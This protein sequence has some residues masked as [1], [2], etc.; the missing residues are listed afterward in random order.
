MVLKQ[1]KE[2]ITKSARKHQYLSWQ[3]SGYFY[4]PFISKFATIDKHEY[5]ASYYGV[6]NL[7]S[8][9]KIYYI[10]VLS[11]YNGN[12][13]LKCGDAWLEGTLTDNTVDKL[14]RMTLS[15]N[16]ENNNTNKL[17]PQLLKKSYNTV[18]KS[19]DCNFDQNHYEYA[20]EVCAHV[21]NFLNDLPEDIFDNLY[22][23]YNQG[24]N[25]INITILNVNNDLQMKFDRYAFKKHILLEGDKGSGKTYAATMWGKEKNITQLFVGGHE[26]FESIDFLGHYIQQKSGEL[27]WKDGS[28][29]EA[30]RKAKVGEKT[31]LILDE[32]LRIPKRELNLLISALSPIDGKYVLRTGRAISSK[33][34]IAIEEVIY[35]PTENLWVIGTTNIGANYAVESMDEALIDRFK[36]IRKDTTKE[37]MRAIL[38]Q[39]AK[40]RKISLIHVDKLV[41]FYSKMNR[42]YLTKIINKIVNIRHLNEALELATNHSE[43][44][45]ILED[46]ILLWVERDYDGYP[47]KEQISAVETVMRT[48]YDYE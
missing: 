25:G 29:S 1:L 22:M 34:D 40:K 21:S 13:M 20:T 42:L 38:L 44:Q 2:I 27:I 46:S 36:P 16:N 30:F 31:I 19:T 18:P 11:F 15:K 4:S 32:I 26:Q 7:V 37:E 12:Y 10:T 28:L 41:D 35:A 45:I 24:L 23:H 6:Y 17:T 5:N 47:N 33:D 3:K 9:P 39:T 48:I 8:N 43:I 14:I